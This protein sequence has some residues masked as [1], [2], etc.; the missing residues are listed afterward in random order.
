MG[1]CRCYLWD[2]LEWEHGAI[3]TSE[4]FMRQLKP[5]QCINCE[6][7]IPLL[8]S[9]CGLWMYGPIC[10]QGWE[11]S[12]Y[13][14][15]AMT[16]I[17]GQARP[18]DDPVFGFSLLHPFLLVERWCLVKN[19]PSQR[20]GSRRKAIRQWKFLQQEEHVP[21]SPCQSTVHTNF[22]GKAGYT[23]SH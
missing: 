7:I 5:K 2:L 21:I 4:I 6:S 22:R 11:A 13:C 18:G 12:N 15:A 20:V 16:A 19:T 9:L 14:Q 23:W 8:S 10:R 17:P 3:Q 1:P